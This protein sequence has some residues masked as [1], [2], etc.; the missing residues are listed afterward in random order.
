MYISFGIVQIVNKIHLLKETWG[1]LEN[2]LF[3]FALPATATATAA[4]NV[5]SF[6]SA[7]YN[8]PDI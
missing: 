3:A 2:N 6:I 5:F 7:R 1:S 8:I 4:E